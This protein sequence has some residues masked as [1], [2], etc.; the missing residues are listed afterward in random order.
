MQRMDEKRKKEILNFQSTSAASMLESVPSKARGRPLI[1]PLLFVKH[2]Q[3]K[4]GVRTIPRP[5]FSIR[6]RGE[7]YNELARKMSQ[8]L[9][10]GNVTKNNKG[11]MRSKCVR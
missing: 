10:Y 1:V 8:L 2:H 6:S 9:G 5:R 3:T 11:I 4:I 7:Q